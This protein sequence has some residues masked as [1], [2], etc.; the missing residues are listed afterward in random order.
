MQCPIMG[1]TIRAR[2]VA[3]QVLALDI[4]RILRRFSRSVILRTARV[5]RAT[6]PTMAV[7]QVSVTDTVDRCDVRTIGA[8]FGLDS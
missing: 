6:P 7:T 3:I 1:R 2:M 8:L 4:D 5:T